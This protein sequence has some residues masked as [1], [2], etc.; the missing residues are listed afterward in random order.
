MNPFDFFDNIYYI[1]LDSRPDREEALLAQAQALDFHPIRMSAVTPKDLGHD[2]NHLAFNASCMKVLE[3]S[4]G[5][6]V[7]VL[8]DDC[9]F[10]D[11]N[12]LSKALSELPH[13]YDMVFLGAN[14]HESGCEYYSEHLVKY[15]SGWTT[16][17]VGYSRQCIEY[18]IDNFKPEEFPIYDEWLRVNVLPR[19]KSFVVC[20]MVADQAKGFSDINQAFSDY[21]FFN[22][23]NNKLKQ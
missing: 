10:G 7:L 14:I 15:I 4:V 8:E 16:H 1:N 12:H 18:I 11:I 21:G 9:V 17:A 6:N 5:N 3:E 19:G 20:P 13:D 23:W 2:N 22:Q